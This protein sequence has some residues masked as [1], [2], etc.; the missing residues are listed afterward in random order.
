MRCERRCALNGIASRFGSVG[1]EEVSIERDGDRQLTEEW[2]SLL[3]AIATHS[4]GEELER[5]AAPQRAKF[6][7][8]NVDV[9]VTL[10]G[11]YVGAC[12]ERSGWV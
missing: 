12:V 11:R 10:R 2:S 9:Y 8:V 3:N 5:T 1:A 7:N 4:C 6:T